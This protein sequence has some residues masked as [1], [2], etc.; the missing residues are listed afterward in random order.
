MLALTGACTSKAPTD[1]QAKPAVPDPAPNV[2]AEP[3]PPQKFRVN[4]DE[5]VRLTPDIEITFRGNSHKISE[6]DIDSPLGISLTVH[7][8]GRDEA[9]DGWVEVSTRG[10]EVAPPRVFTAAGIELELVDYDYDRWIEVRIK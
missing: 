4:L 6:G 2:P 1:T 10:V 7:H 8:D 3:A 9:W 5:R